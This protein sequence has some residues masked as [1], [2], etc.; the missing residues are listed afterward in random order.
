M[1]GTTPKGPVI[2]LENLFWLL[3]FSLVTATPFM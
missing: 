2:T 1:V 3:S